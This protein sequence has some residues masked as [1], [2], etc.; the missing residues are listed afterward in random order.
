M[1]QHPTVS[2]YQRVTFRLNLRWS[3]AAE[4]PSKV[5]GTNRSAANVARVNHARRGARVNLP[6]KF[7][8]TAGTLVLKFVF[9]VPG[10]Y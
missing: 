2:R 1:E 5:L 9:V 4:W 8:A 7:F 3:P 10:H 6:G